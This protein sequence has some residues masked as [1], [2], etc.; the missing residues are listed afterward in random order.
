MPL[1]RL[2]QTDDR[3]GTRPLLL[4]SDAIHH[5]E[6]AEEGGGSKVLT[7]AGETFAV[8]QTL[9]QLAELGAG[10]AARSPGARMVAVDLKAVRAAN[11]S[12]LPSSFHVKASKAPAWG[13][14]HPAAHAAAVLR[15]E[16]GDVGANEDVP[17]RDEAQLADDEQ[18][19]RAKA[20][21]EARAPRRP[22]ALREP[23][24][25]ERETVERTD[26]VQEAKAQ[27]TAPRPPRRRHRKAEQ[28]AAEEGATYQ[29]GGDEVTPTTL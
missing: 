15:A 20:A 22:P 17:K 24:P 1:I 29:R 6:P 21:N 11:P 7:T 12:D 5:A 9:D 16:S 3:G 23:L 8:S 26:A 28:P 27:Q 2:T 13:E 18:T 14:A 19:E 10:P 4:N 25:A